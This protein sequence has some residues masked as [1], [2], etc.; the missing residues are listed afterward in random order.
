MPSTVSRHYVKPTACLPKG[1]P[2]QVCEGKT[3]VVS[4][5]WAYDDSCVVTVD[6]DGIIKLYKATDCTPMG[7]AM[8]CNEQTACAKIGKKSL[9]YAAGLE[10]GSIMIWDLKGLVG[11]KNSITNCF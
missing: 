8:K 2:V 7:E 11:V 1:N 6:E 9:V 5:D 3:S 4:V 10:T